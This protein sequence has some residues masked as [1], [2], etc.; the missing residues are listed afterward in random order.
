MFSLCFASLL[1]R[2]CTGAP[3]FRAIPDFA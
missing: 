2:G 1:R 3:I